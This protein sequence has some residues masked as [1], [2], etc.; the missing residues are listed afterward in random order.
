V[1][2]YLNRNIFNMKP[3]ILVLSNARIESRKSEIP[4]EKLCVRPYEMC[5]TITRRGYRE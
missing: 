3:Y 4:K 1:L 5:G 2:S